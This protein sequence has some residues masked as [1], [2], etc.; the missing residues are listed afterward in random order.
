MEAVPKQVTATVIARHPDALCVI[1]LVDRQAGGCETGTQGR[2]VR[3]QALCYVRASRGRR[4]AGTS[5]RLAHRRGGRRRTRPRLVAAD[6]ADKLEELFER[7][8]E[9]EALVNVEIVRRTKRGAPMDLSLSLALLRGPCGRITGVMAV[10]TDMTERKRAEWTARAFA[11]IGHELVE[12][13]DPTKVTDRIVT[14]VFERF[15]AVRVNLYRLDPRSRALVCVATAGETGPDAW[16]GTALLP[17]ESFTA[18]AVEEGRLGWSPDVL[19]DLRVMEPAWVRQ[20]LLE[21]GCGPVAAFPLVA[22]GQVLGAL[23]L[24]CSC[25]RTLVPRDFKLLTAFA[26]DAAVALENARL[27]QKAE[28]G[29]RGSRCSA[30]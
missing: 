18:R 10:V 24:A 28:D 19:A 3:E 14:T 2:R 15:R 12:T 25:E 13:L 17:G 5:R 30:A 20:R 7:G 22:R 11:R 21:E 6:A 8:L 23:A 9:G 16:L 27:Y 26:G 29:A 4:P 1:R